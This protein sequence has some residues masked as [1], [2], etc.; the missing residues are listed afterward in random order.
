M[1]KLQQKNISGSEANVLSTAERH[2]AQQISEW[3]TDYLVKALKIKR[4]E[5]DTDAKFERYSVDSLVLVVMTEELESWLGF[6]IDPTAPFEAPTIN[7]LAKYLEERQDN[8]NDNP[9]ANTDGE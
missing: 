6:P 8:I 9:P 4:T 1:N 3:L 2:S 5:I 7:S